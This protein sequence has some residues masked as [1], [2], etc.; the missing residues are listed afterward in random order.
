L[1]DT[2]AT[3]Y[4]SMPSVSTAKMFLTLTPGWHSFTV[5]LQHK[6]LDRMRGFGMTPILPAFAGHVPKVLIDI[7]KPNYTELV[8]V[9]FSQ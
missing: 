3:A 9:F 2:N 5:D 8:R 7:Y 6:I 1:L 4:F